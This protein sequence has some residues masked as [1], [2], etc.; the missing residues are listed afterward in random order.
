MVRDLEKLVHLLERRIKRRKAR[1]K[2]K[3]R[4]VRTKKM[5]KTQ[6][7]KK[8]KRNPSQNLSLARDQLL[9][10]RRKLSQATDVGLL[11]LHLNLYQ[12]IVYWCQFN[13]VD[14]IPT[15]WLA[16][17][18]CST[19]NFSTTW[20]SPLTLVAWVRWL[21]LFMWESYSYRG[22]LWASRLMIWRR[23][24]TCSAS[25]RKLISSPNSRSCMLMSSTSVLNLPT[26]LTSR[27]VA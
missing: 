14:L 15:S 16:W 6:L 5:G 23:L 10:R 18:S 11:L 7:R 12:N 17:C 8:R 2:W 9:P 22:F 25:S 24:W 21:I 4:K 27:L 19:R 1:K 20:S 26:R 13:L 3:R